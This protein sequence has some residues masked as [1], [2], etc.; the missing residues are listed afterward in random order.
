MTMALVPRPQ[1]LIRPI[2]TPE[3]VREALDAFIKIRDACLDESDK[4]Y[5][6]PDGTISV[7]PIKGGTVFI[8]KSGWRKVALAFNLDW[9]ILSCE[10]INSE[11]KNGK[12]FLY[13]VQVK[14]T[15]PNGR[16]VINIGS[17]S[18]RNPFFSKKK[19]VEKIV[20][21]EN[22][23]M[24]AQTVALNRAISDIVGSGEVSAEEIQQE[25]KNKPKPETEESKK[26]GRAREKAKPEPE[27]YP[28]HKGKA[29]SDDETPTE[30]DRQFMRIWL[31][32]CLNYNMEVGTYSKLIGKCNNAQTLKELRE[33]ES[34]LGPLYPLPEKEK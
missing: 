12:F 19:G 20:E 2:A 27:S 31:K 9:E 10:L 5:R 25:E 1:T 26:S 13:E 21:P 6:L 7:H 24:M 11:D 14:V 16:S 3:S 23:V 29:R 32:N 22:I 17:C 4:L 8:K 33:M 18:S 30:S 28:E 15:A 34:Y